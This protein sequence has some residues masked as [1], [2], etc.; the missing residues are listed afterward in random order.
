MLQRR[1]MITK[2]QI[3]LHFIRGQGNTSAAGVLSPD[4]LSVQRPHFVWLV[5]Q[6]GL[7]A[8]RNTASGLSNSLATARDATSYVMAESKFL[9]AATCS[10]GYSK[11]RLRVFVS[12]VVP[13]RHAFRARAWCFSGSAWPAAPSPCFW[14]PASLEVLALMS[15][16]LKALSQD[17][18]L[19]N[20]FGKVG[21]LRKLHAPSSVRQ[22]HHRHGCYMATLGQ[23]F[24][25]RSGGSLSSKSVSTRSRCAP[26]S[27]CSGL[28]RVAALSRVLQQAAAHLLSDVS[29]AAAAAAHLPSDGRFPGSCRRRG[30]GHEPMTHLKK[31]SC[32]RAK[33]PDAA[34]AVIRRTHP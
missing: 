14:G 4:S 20:L 5:Q 7:R 16:V 21:A 25:L 6:L 31:G 30:G 23:I 18:F 15:L 10:P 11:A 24:R 32:G 13:R 33:K 19:A 1:D 22:C 26:P 34:A 2:H 29:A 8:R 27:R 9:Y 28:A 12:M 17:V 3:T